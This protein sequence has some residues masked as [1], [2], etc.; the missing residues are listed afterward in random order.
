MS[1]EQVTGQGTSA[2][3]DLATRLF[4]S[5]G[6][7]FSSS[8][9]LGQII[10][11]RVLRQYEGSRYLVSFSGEEKVVDSAVPLSTNDVIHGRVVGLGVR[12]ELQR[13]AIERTMT[14]DVNALRDGQRNITGSHERMMMETL[15][16]YQV[17]LSDVD[18]AV[19][20]RLVK[21]ASDPASTLLVG[22]L[23][24]KI[25]LNQSPELLRAVSRHLETS[26]G[27]VVRQADR[28]ALPLDT[29]LTTDHGPRHDEN[30]L[31]SRIAA[32]LDFVPHRPASPEP[33][34]AEPK[35]VFLDTSPDEPGVER[36][37]TS[38]S[39]S[40]QDHEFNL[41]RW[42]LNVQSD[43]TVSHRVGTVPFLLGDR[44][45]EVEVAVFD[46]R[47]GTTLRDGV[48]HRQLVFSLD[49]DSLGHLEIVARVAGN[50]LRVTVRAESSEI[51]ETLAGFMGPLRGGLSAGGWFVD[52][53][54]YETCERQKSSCVTRSA[55]EH[56][57]CQDSLN[58][59]M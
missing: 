8:L 15:S 37:D 2:T 39:G 14:D 56:L 40:Q 5:S 22:V 20:S 46:Q 52:E 25:G 16:R 12:V 27:S 9:R 54:V 13:V 29:Q 17:V 53:L 57:I 31:A 21:S 7:D 44:L 19:L 55:V 38:D 36:R 33:D 6:P 43:G 48:R 47:E 41:G 45:I 51:T 30:E 23:L 3:G 42:L 59:L 28:A 1:I 4:L 26:T 11:G 34:E 35:P 24:S 58:R 32:M 18:T 50:R 10:K 49:L